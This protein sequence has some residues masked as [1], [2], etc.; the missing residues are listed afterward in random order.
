MGFQFEYCA[1]KCKHSPNIGKEISAGYRLR[2]LQITTIYLLYTSYKGV[3]E[4]V[5]VGEGVGEE[6]GVGEG[7]MYFRAIRAI[8]I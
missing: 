5:R 6:V 8:S 3:G 1:G 4:G 7:V 2:T